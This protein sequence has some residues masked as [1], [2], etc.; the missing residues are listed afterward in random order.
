MADDDPTVFAWL[1]QEQVAMPAAPY[2]YEA[3]WVCFAL[4]FC[5]TAEVAPVRSTWYYI[6]LSEYIATVDIVI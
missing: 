5:T 6:N 1:L 3:G 4:C 2:S